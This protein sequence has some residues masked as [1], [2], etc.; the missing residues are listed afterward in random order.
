MTAETR[1]TSVVACIS[2]REYA[3]HF[4]CIRAKYAGY[5]LENS[6]ILEVPELLWSCSAWRS[7]HGEQSAHQYLVHS[8]ERHM[9]KCRHF[10]IVTLLQGQWKTVKAVLN[11]SYVKDY[12][13]LPLITP[14]L[15]SD[16]TNC[17]LYWSYCWTVILVLYRYSER[18]C[19]L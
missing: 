13:N 10:D 9:E 19:K 3:T 18:L 12:N 1:E 6:G 2:I 17:K 16:R 5:I 7:G 11:P 4:W 15:F 8:G 14:F